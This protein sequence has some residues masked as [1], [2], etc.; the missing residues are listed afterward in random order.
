[1]FQRGKIDR[2][3][4]V[5]SRYFGSFNAADWNDQVQAT[6]INNGLRRLTDYSRS[7]ENSELR[8]DI[9]HSCI[10]ILHALYEVSKW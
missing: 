4:Y 8:I 5:R 7:R 6:S 3:G 9:L 10:V 1:M 2:N